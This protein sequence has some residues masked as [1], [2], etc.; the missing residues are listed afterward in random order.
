[1]YQASDIKK[2]AV[3]VNLDLSTAFDVISHDI[4]LNRL[5]VEFEMLNTAP[6][7]LTSY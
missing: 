4:L 5:D 1:M 7:W 6:A 2:T 3:L